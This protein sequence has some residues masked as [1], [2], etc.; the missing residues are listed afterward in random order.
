MKPRKDPGDKFDQKLYEAL[1][2]GDKKTRLQRAFQA[3]NEYEG[4][5]LKVREE[6]LKVV[7]L[8]C[9]WKEQYRRNRVCTLIY[10]P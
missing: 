6:S 1:P 4:T 7:K 5:Y 2:E 10:N 3:L 8:M 9:M